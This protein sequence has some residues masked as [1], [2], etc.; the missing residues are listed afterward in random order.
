MASNGAS[1][2]ADGLSDAA[3]GA[4][5]AD[6]VVPVQATTIAAVPSNAANRRGRLVERV[7]RRFSS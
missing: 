5:L 3:D 2:E 4:T 1:A 6:G 7:M